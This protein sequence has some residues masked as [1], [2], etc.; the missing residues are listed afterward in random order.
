MNTGNGKT[1]PSIMTKSSVLFS[2]NKHSASWSYRRK[3]MGIVKMYIIRSR[4]VYGCDKETLYHAKLFM[5][6][7]CKNCKRVVLSQL[8]RIQSVSKYRRKYLNLSFNNILGN[9]LTNMGYRYRFSNLLCT[10]KSLKKFSPL[11]K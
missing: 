11:W 6:H 9:D 4:P 3:Y 7:F 2:L 10:Y 8:F 5:V 1:L